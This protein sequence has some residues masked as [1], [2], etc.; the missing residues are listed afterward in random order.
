MIPV[1]FWAFLAAVCGRADAEDVG[2]VVW[3]LRGKCQKKTGGFLRKRN[4]RIG[5]KQGDGADFAAEVLQAAAQHLY[6]ELST[7][8]STE[9]SGV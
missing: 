6:A 8:R 1:D 7:C 2:D 5:A 9:C 3:L 4:G